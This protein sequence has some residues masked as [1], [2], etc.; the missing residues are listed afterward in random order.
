MSIRTILAFMLLPVLALTAACD[1]KGGASGT[2]SPV[3][4]ID[5]NR[6]YMESKSGKQGMEILQGMSSDLQSQ[7]QGLQEEMAK[8]GSE[9]DK[10]ERNRRFQQTLSASQARMGAEQNRIVAILQ[11]NVEAVLNDY[12]K[13]HGIALIMPVEAALSYDKSADITDE[14]IA[15][16][17]KREI[18]LSKPAEQAPAQPAEQPAEPRAPAAEQPAPAQ[19]PAEKPA[20]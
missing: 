7:I 4:L 5:Q 2:S 16:L 20:Q 12:R 13:E 3:A 19:Q 18:D 17:D 15:A 14:I 9:Q 8:E 1:D 11:E 10:Q 6:L